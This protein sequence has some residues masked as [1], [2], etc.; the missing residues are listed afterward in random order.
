MGGELDKKPEV[1][2]EKT[3]QSEQKNNGAPEKQSGS[4]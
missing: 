4:I 3:E 1:T 2:P